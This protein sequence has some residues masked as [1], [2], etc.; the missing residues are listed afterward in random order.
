M[1]DDCAI[2]ALWRRACHTSE[3]IYLATVVHVEGSSYRKSGARMLVTAGGERAGTISGG[4]LEAE[5]SQM[6]AWHTRNGSVVHTYQSSFDDDFEGVPYGLGCGGT[7]WILMQTEAEA[8]AVL[9]AMQRALEQRVSSVVVCSFDRTRPTQQ[10]LQE[11]DLACWSNV[12]NGSDATAAARMA[13][14]TRRCVSLRDE[15]ADMLPSL[16]CMPICPPTR[17][18]IFGA[19]DD[20]KPIVEFAA[21]LGWQT[22]LADGRSHLLRKERFPRALS[23]LV[24]SY[25]SQDSPNPLTLDEAVLPTL[26]AD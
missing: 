26:E 19:G 11:D 18:Y 20:V 6:I 2:V 3:P 21:E 8:T 17:V 15:I 24:L 12:A 5:I 10:M 9:H 4:C 14:D 7:I 1:Q 23:L 16:V 22:H 13:L 25:S